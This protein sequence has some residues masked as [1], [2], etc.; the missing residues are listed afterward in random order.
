LRLLGVLVR[1][2]LAA[3]AIAVVSVTVAN[4]PTRAAV[5]PPA[6][7][8]NPFI[9]TH[10]EGNTFP[11]PSAPFGM[12]QLSPDTGHSTGYGWAD[13]RIRGFSHTHLSGAGCPAM[14]DV[15]FM[16]TTGPVDQTSSDAY[17]SPFDHATESAHP[18]AYA[19]T[20]A[21]YG[22]RAELTTTP[23]T[24]WHRYTFPATNQANV[25][26]NIGQAD[27]TTFG[28]AIRVVGDRQ[29][30]GQVTSG[31]FC[32]APNR[33]TVRFT[34]TFDRPFAAY[35]TWRDGKLQAGG[36]ESSAGGSNESDGA[37]VS[38]DTRSDRDVV[39]K[40]ALSYVSVKGAERNL[41]TEAP[42]F[43][44]DAVRAR[45][46][47]AWAQALARAQ[48]DGGTPQQRESF[49][50]ALYRAQLTPTTFSDVDGR[51]AGFD[52][53]VHWTGG[54]TQYANLSLWDTYRPQNQLLE[55][56]VPDV[57][58]NVQLSL[59]ADG[60]QNGGWLPRWPMASGD[61]NVM[62]G[63]PVAPF[64]ADG[65][66][67]GLLRGHERGVFRLLY[68]N[69]TSVPP[70]RVGTLGRVGN[71][72]YTR[73][74]YVPFDAGHNIAKDGDDDLHQGASATL[75][76]AL[77]DC[78]SAQLASGL[79]YRNKA[80]ELRRRA[81]SY[82]KIW[83]RRNREFRA[84]LASGRWAPRASQNGSGFHEG[85]P[86]QYTWLVPQDLDGLIGLL[87]GRDRA[88]AQLDR[89]FANG[90][91]RQW[92]TEPY[93]Y[94]G[95]PTY[96]PNNEPDLHAPWIYA[97]LGR[98]WRTTTMVR[99]AQ[100]LFAPEP[101]GLTGNDD[102]GT[103]S[104]WYVFASLGLYPVTPGSPFYALHTPLFPHA[105][106]AAGGRRLTIDAPGTSPASPYVS[107][108]TVGGQPTTKAWITHDA[109]LRAASLRFATS[110]KPS[111]TWGTHQRD[112]PPSPCR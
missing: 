29:L 9:G 68:R 35:G 26:V 89:F 8:V 19:V 47:A 21:R 15:P 71:P 3:V 11:G 62:T 75:E 99:A 32:S 95:R 77:S 6:S 72:D 51:Y 34:A 4:S 79:G 73:L 49:Y 20:L 66:A 37:Y 70:P 84:R 91:V 92:V 101:G 60:Q 94:Y 1:P 30:E 106:V 109:L 45:A 63:D 82:R 22:V 39:A 59:V 24:G 98:P 36:R 74:G 107:S 67:K 83:D 52:G 33:Y 85:T 44:F 64:L 27:Q 86:A 93:G 54:R 57:A 108:L 16:P 40:V 56:L 10:D 7:S 87:G 43:D 55:L 61:T 41:A 111:A 80:R 28:S 96:N 48:V 53:R 5:D 90:D 81:Q 103:M 112:A 105:S 18:G 104:A 46:E 23:R 102:L 31:H 14:G 42:G 13:G 12:V 76:Y 65:W 25:L 58:R 69:A 50:S 38:F 110:A 17:A 100:S 88:A 78:S 2:L 97:W